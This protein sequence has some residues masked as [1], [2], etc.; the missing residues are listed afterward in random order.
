MSARENAPHGAQARANNGALNGGPTHDERGHGSSTDCGLLAHLLHL[1]VLALGELVLDCSSHLVALRDHV[2]HV[3]CAQRQVLRLHDPRP[4]GKQRR[5]DQHHAGHVQRDNLGPLEVCVVDGR[6]RHAPAR[7]S[8][9]AAPKC[10]RVPPPL[11]RLMACPARAQAPASRRRQ[12]PEERQRAPRHHDGT[13]EE[14]VL[15]H[16]FFQ[17][18]RP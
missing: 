16:W 4:A 9:P 7:R 8:P 18:L 10:R 15:Q 6:P 11:C 5:V 14:G 2:G 12:P 13:H 17:G 3:A 1:F